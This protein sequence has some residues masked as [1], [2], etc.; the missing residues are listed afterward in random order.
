MEGRVKR[1]FTHMDLRRMPYSVHRTPL[2]KN[3]KKRVIMNHIMVI[4][5]G[6]HQHK[7]VRARAQAG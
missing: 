3:K 4:V 7:K 6:R 5:V 1:D 2:K